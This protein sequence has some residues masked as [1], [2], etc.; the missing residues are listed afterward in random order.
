MSLAWAP[1]APALIASLGALSGSAWGL[2]EAAAVEGEEPVAEGEEPIAEGETVGNTTGDRN[3]D[4]VPPAG[5]LARRAN[6]PDRRALAETVL[7]ELAST[8]F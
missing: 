1:G 4:G 3:S 5:V 2:A 7:R 8:I 6:L